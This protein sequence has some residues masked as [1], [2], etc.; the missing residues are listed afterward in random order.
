MVASKPIFPGA[1]TPADPPEADPVEI[2]EKEEN[3]DE[4]QKDKDNLER[5]TRRAARKVKGL[6]HCA[7]FKYFV[8]L[9]LDPNKIDR[10]DV[11]TIIRKMSQWCD[12]KVRRNGLSYI[13]IP[14]KHKNG[15]IH[16]HG[17]FTDALEV[18]DSG[19]ISRPGRKKPQRPRS[20]RQ[21][22]EWLAE[23]GHTVYN[24]PAWT[25]GF[26]TAIELYGEK[27]QAINYVCKYLTKQVTENGDK[28]GG[29]WYYHGGKFEEPVIRT[30]NLDLPS[31]LLS[32][33]G[34][35]D[36]YYIREIDAAG[37]ALAIRY[38]QEEPRWKKMEHL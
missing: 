1:L 33:S 21:R 8:T 5:A 7:K 28:I 35:I 38:I 18:V 17:F 31:L 6:C 15:A 16:F 22:E 24:L 2:V 4:N 10:F 12:N 3:G 36:T 37:I 30:D 19:T 25:L 27:Q 14:E 9:T 34:I 32:G 26:T 11:P 20:K 23:G 13:L 29:R